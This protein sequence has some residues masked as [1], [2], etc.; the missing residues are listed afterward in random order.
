M[1]SGGCAGMSSFPPSYYIIHPN[2]ALRAVLVRH[3]KAG[4]D[5]SW[6]LTRDESGYTRASFQDWVTMVKVMFIID[7]IDMKTMFE[8]ENVSPDHQRA[9]EE[10][11][12]EPPYGVEVFDKWWTL[13]RLDSGPRAF[14]DILK[15]VSLPTLQAL[16]QTGQAFVD[17]WMQDVM[18]LKAKGRL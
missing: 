16:D 3:P 11:L 13:E 7:L 8:Q 1:A 12:G 18:K 14:E 10:L 9:F 15:A 4:M 2:P 6:V 5:R 17:R